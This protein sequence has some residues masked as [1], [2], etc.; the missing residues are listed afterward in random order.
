MAIREWQLRHDGQFPAELEDLVPGLL[1][2]LP[3]DPYSGKPFRYVEWTPPRPPKRDES[4]P[5]GFMAG[6]FG[7]GWNWPAGTRLLYS[8]GPDRND[9][10]G[11]QP[12]HQA[13]TGDIIFDIP[14]IAPTAKA[15][16]VGAQETNKAVVDKPARG[17]PKP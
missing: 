14:P 1:A 15:A 8:V 4:G 7:N 11:R 10:R 2:A 12:L 16:T 17:Q 6:G 5:A 3:V 9:D 13:D